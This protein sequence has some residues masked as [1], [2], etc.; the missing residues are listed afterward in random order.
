MKRVTG[1]HMQ[2]PADIWRRMYHPSR[3]PQQRELWFKLLYNALPLG[4]RI[5]HFRPSKQQCPHCPGHTQTLTHF[6]H[7]CTLAQTA[8]KSLSN[9]LSIPIATQHTALYGWPL[10]TNYY[11]VAEGVRR[12]VGHAMTIRTLW[13]AHTAAIYNDQ[14]ASISAIPTQLKFYMADYISL[15]YMI[16]KKRHAISHFWTIW[17]NIGEVQD[18]TFSFHV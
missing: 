14:K 6:T 16:S 11:S 13:L 4:R 9:L 17:E 15:L 8:W 2:P 5:M 7:S 1:Q 10:Q 12:Q 18:G 3:L